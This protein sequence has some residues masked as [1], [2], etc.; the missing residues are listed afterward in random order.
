M[1]CAPT[2]GNLAHSP[3]SPRQALS[4]HCRSLNLSYFLQSIFLH[5]SA[6]AINKIPC[7]KL[8]N[9]LVDLSKPMMAFFDALGFVRK[10]P[11]KSHP[12]KELTPSI[13]ESN[14]YT[15][16][17]KSYPYEEMSQG[18]PRPTF[19]SLL[20]SPHRPKTALPQHEDEL[21]RHLVESSNQ[22]LKPRATDNDDYVTRDYSS[23]SEST[24]LKAKALVM[25]AQLFYGNSVIFAVKRKE[26]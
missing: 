20:E 23:I 4:P 14:G 26:R 24:K 1:C 12:T 18:E 17:M 6:T 11:T 10:K 16:P 5:F 8:P 2:T 7:R 15:N 9:L 22:D 21:L 3:Y 13:H 25:R 19:G